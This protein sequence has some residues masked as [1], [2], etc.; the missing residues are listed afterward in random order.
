MGQ[1]ADYGGGEEAERQIDEEP[2]APFVAA[3]VARGVEEAGA[4]EPHHREDG[5]ELDEDLEGL[6]ALAGEPEQVAC[7]DQVAGGGDGEELG[8][9]LDE[10]EDRRLDQQDEVHA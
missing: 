2:A 3:Q 10:P 9:P 8:D 7:H 4:V 1:E 5:P 6:G